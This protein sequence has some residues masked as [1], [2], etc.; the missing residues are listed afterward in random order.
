MTNSLE[1][2]AV[3]KVAGEDAA[4][5]YLGQMPSARFARNDRGDK[6]P[7][8][9]VPFPASGSDMRHAHRV[10]VP[11]PRRVFGTGRASD[12][13]PRDPCDIPTTSAPSRPS[14]R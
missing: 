3:L 5:D 10:T 14:P 4:L 8:E 9:A 11:L 12:R 13:R 2:Y 1:G 7:A 6:A